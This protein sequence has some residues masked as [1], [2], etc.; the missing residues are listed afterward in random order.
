MS[1]QLQKLADEIYYNY[2]DFLQKETLNSACKSFLGRKDIF[3]LTSDLSVVT[4]KKDGKIYVNEP[5]AQS[6][7]SLMAVSIDKDTKILEMIA[8]LKTHIIY[9]YIFI[10]ICLSNDEFIR[11]FMKLYNK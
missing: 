1:E 4:I 9:L 6:I 10:N 5:F 8:P 3:S 7:Y 11:D 2:M